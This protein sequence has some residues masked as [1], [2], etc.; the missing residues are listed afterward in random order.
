VVVAEGYINHVG[1]HG[2]EGVDPL[3]FGAVGGDAFH[4]VASAELAV[5]TPSEQVEF[6]CL[7]D[8][9]G[10]STSTYDCF[11]GLFEFKLLW[12]VQVGLR[13]MA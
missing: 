4:R 11:N 1:L 10:V 9:P 5:P 12:L 6:S 8:D 7:R 2:G 3:W 13:F